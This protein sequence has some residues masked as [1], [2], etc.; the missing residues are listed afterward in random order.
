[1]KYIIFISQKTTIY[2]EVW[3]KSQGICR[4]AKSSKMIYYCEC[5][6]AL[7]MYLS[8]HSLFLIVISNIICK[9]QWLLLKIKYFRYDCGLW[10]PWFMVYYQ[11]FIWRVFWI[12]LNV[13]IKAKCLCLWYSHVLVLL[14]ASW[15]LFIC[16]LVL[17][18]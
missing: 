12:I 17:G 16:T 18:W 5:L 15:F 14:K 7:M 1:M 13:N 10:I 2:K 11:L 3:W 4:F 8:P 9:F 6:A